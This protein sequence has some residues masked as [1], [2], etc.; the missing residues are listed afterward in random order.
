ME[1]EGIA[2]EAILD[3]VGLA[4]AGTRLGC[5]TLGL[6]TAKEAARAVWRDFCDSDDV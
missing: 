1:A 4:I 5:A 2:H 6:N 3:E